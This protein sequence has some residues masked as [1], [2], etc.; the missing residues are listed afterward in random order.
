MTM[1]TPARALP[2]EQIAISMNP[3]TEPFWQA[4]REHRLTACRCADC[5]HF[6]M[7]PTP[8]CPE[9]SSRA[10]DW[11]TLP[12]TGSVFSYVVCHRNPATGEDFVYVP[13]VVELDGAPG[14]RLVANLTGCDAEDAAIGIRV[15][16]D[17]TPIQNGWVLPNFRKA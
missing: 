11:P 16:V 3:D 14:A 1:A 13:I 4:A 5:G 9:C 15:A 12:G 17:W 8:L 2:S 6:R 7:P 10:K